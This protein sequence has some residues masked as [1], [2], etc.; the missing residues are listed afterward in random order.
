ML[1]LRFDKCVEN[2]GIPAYNARVE[3]VLDTPSPT[4]TSPTCKEV[5]MADESHT[6]TL[7]AALLR[8]LLHYDPE[9]G[10]FTWKRRGRHH[11][12]SD[13]GCNAWNAVNVGREA[14]KR[15]SPYRQIAVFGRRYR[16]ARLAWLYMT[17][18]WPPYFV[19]HKDGNTA[20]NRWSNLR[21]ATPSQNLANRGLPANSSTGFKGVSR[22][23]KSR[24]FRAVIKAEGRY[25]HL[26]FYDTA[27]EAHAAYCAAATKY[28][29]EF[30]RGSW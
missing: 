15:N 9:T 27:E 5:E 17:G 29:G 14:G 20:N 12:P 30:A 4:L 8:E 28:Y 18:E 2:I 19:D 21:S 22:H 25:I 6:T 24:R 1:R 13:K 23:Q 3:E 10:V 26:G 16:P 7:T 11:F